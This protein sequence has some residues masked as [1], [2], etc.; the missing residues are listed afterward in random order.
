MTI[1][2]RRKAKFRNPK[3]PPEAGGKSN[4]VDCRCWRYKRQK[5]RKKSAGDDARKTLDW[6]LAVG[7]FLGLNKAADH[8][9][10]FLAGTGWDRTLSRDEARQF[11]FIRAAE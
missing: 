9:E 5:E 1:L 11:D 6:R 4:A 8:L 3:A 2:D 10:A 7:R